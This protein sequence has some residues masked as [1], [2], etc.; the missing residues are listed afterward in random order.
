MSRTIALLSGLFLLFCF[1]PAASDF[2]SAVMANP[3][4]ST[5]VQTTPASPGA[6]AG[7]QKSAP[8]S[9][10]ILSSTANNTREVV[11]IWVGRVESN[12]IYSKDGKRFDFNNATRVIKNIQPGTT[13]R[14]AEL[15]YENNV[16]LFVTIR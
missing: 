15:V 1:L 7:A 3:G 9:S 16:L 11:N 8:G 4:Q 14:T 6:S 2:A 10:A 12:A 5:S 13:Q